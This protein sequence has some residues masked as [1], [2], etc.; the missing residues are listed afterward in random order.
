MQTI[1]RIVA[2][3]A[4]S[5]AAVPVTATAQSGTSRGAARE[6][7]E[8]FLRASAQLGKPTAQGDIGWPVPFGSSPGALFMPF[9]A[10]HSVALSLAPDGGA[11]GV[12]RQLRTATYVE[13]VA[14]TVALRT[15]VEALTLALQQRIAAPPD[16]CTPPLGGPAYLFAAQRVMRMWT[17]GLA[18][19]A[20]QLTWEVTTGPVYAITIVAGVG[21]APA[22]EAWL[23]CPRA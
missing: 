18:T 19:H 5:L 17:N 11:T 13:R 10:A 22:G 12:A 4:V 15:R 14:D 7:F 9:T 21:A 3:A 1:I 8:T 20:T 23:A 2:V 16:R 6:A